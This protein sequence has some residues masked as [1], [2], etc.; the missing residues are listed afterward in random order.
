MTTVPKER[1]R[2]VQTAKGATHS[3]WRDLAA[4][5]SLANLCFFGFWHTILFSTPLLAPAWTWR[6]LLAITVNVYAFAALFWMLISQ[7]KRSRRLPGWHRGL[8]LLAPL[9]LLRLLELRYYRP[10]RRLWTAVEDDSL[11]ILL[12]AATVLLA[13]YA[14]VRWRR[15]LLVAA[16][17]LTLC[18]FAFVPASFLQAAWVVHG[19]RAVA[20]AELMASPPL[21]PVRP[22]QRR[23]VWIVFDEMDWRYVFPRRPASLRLPEID[24]L[25]AQSIYA[26]S[27]FQ[28]GLE[29]SE[30]MMSYLYG[31]QVYSVEPTGKANFRLLFLDEPKQID[32][33]GPPNLFSKV[34][35][36]GF[37]TAMVGWFLPYCR[38]FKQSLN[39]CYLESMETR[40][41]GSQPDLATSFRSQLRTLSPLEARQRHMER[42]LAMLQEAKQ[43]A[44][45]PK[46]GLVVLHLPV[47][48]EPAIYRRDDAELTIFN[49]RPDWYF[50][51][52]ALADRTLGDLRM[53]MERAGLWDASTVLVTS[54][55][56]LRWYAMLDQTMDPR[57]PFLVKLAGQQQEVVYHAPLRSLVA[58]DLT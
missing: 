32:G 22:G 44:A 29:T 13:A 55:H 10:L 35:Q 18:L 50:D 6:D 2:E 38:L 42:Y 51:N 7:G 16:E 58:H 31:R 33:P 9:I 11:L 30:S 48:H 5:A 28:S 46:L 3:R 56:S 45:D 15:S 14:V 24:R 40:V 23:V 36:A 37:N 47:P 49:F 25:R 39:R 19:D 43:A 54:D 34:R 12:T 53:E 41:R 17:V 1:V 8:Y 4:A 57:V 27:A 52:L 26:E 21:L 20:R